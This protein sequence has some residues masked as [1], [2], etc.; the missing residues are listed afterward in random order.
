MIH[1]NLNLNNL[2]PIAFRPQSWTNN[3]FAAQVKPNI[4]CY[5]LF[6]NIYAWLAKSSDYC[7][8]MF[9]ELFCVCSIHGCDVSKY[10]GPLNTRLRCEFVR[11]GR[12]CYVILSPL[13]LP[14]LNRVEQFTLTE[15]VTVEV[16]VSYLSAC[17]IRQQKRSQLRGL[18]KAGGTW[19]AVAK[20]I[21]PK[22]LGMIVQSQAPEQT[23]VLLT[24]SIN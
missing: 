12:R 20:P 16:L 5:P 18:H 9:A 15:S 22:I 10:F 24:I 7:D 2:P 4:K 13:W 17:K 6:P 19:Q 23:P 11:K 8:Y 21:H 1:N 14:M 3:R